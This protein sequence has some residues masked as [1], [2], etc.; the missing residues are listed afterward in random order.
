MKQNITIK[1]I[2]DLSNNAQIKISKWCL[3]KKY[4]ADE[5]SIG[6]MIEFLT[7]YE[8]KGLHIYSTEPYLAL[9][10]RINHEKPGHMWSTSGWTLDYNT[11]H[12]I[13]YVNNKFEIIEL[14]D[15]LWEAV[16]SL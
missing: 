16:K 6:Q 7:E 1:E 11:F 5:L 2:Q 15:C 3:D 8:E 10:N 9:S 13:D 14:C 4:K 12:S